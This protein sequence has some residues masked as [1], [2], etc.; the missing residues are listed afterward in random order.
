ME[1]I[2]Y[3]EAEKVFDLR[4]EHSTY[5]MQVRE[6]DTLVHL[7]YGSPVGDA[8]ITDRIVC[9]D[10]G[11]SGNPYE[12]EKDRTFSLDTLPQ[13][14]TAYGN[15]DYR[16]NGLETEQADGSDTANLKFESYEIT[17]GKYSLKGL[18]AMFAK[19]DEAETLEIVLT[20]RVSGLK[21]HLLYGVFPHLDVITRAVRL[22][23]TGTA[24]V[25]VKKAMSMEMDY[26]Y[27][28]LDAVHFYGRH[29][30]ERQMERTHLGHGNW[31]VGSIR[32]TSSHHHN[33]FV[34]LCDRNTE[35]TYGDCYGYALAYSGNFLFETEV[36]QVGHTRVAMG[37]H[38]YH[39]SWTLEQGESFETPEV[40]MAYSA[41]GF[42]KLSRIYHDAYRSNLIRS[43]YTEQPRPILVN[44]WEATYFD[45]D[46]DKIYHIA[47]EAKNIGLDM[48]VLDDGWFG[49]RDND[50]CALGDWE[51]NEEKIKGGLPAL[52]ERIH[53]LGLKFG[54]WVEPEMISE[55]SDLYRAHP[56]WILQT[57]QRH[58]CH[59]RNQY[60]LDFSRKEVV[61]CIYEMMYKIL[62]EAKV[63][64]IKWDMNRSITEC[65]SAAL[66]ADRQGEVFHRYILGVYDLYERLNTA[67]PQILFESCASGG[68]RFDPGI[69]YYAPQGWTSDDTDAAERV[70][71]QYG[72]SMCYP[73]SS[74]GSHV[75]VVP[76][77]Q[78]NRKTPLHTRANV[79]YFGTF[80]YELDLNKL[81]DEEI[82]EV[83]QQITF[84]KEYRELIQFGTFYRLKSP[85]EGNET[86]WMT[87]SE[88]KKTA[89]VFWYRERN[90]VNADF[91]RVRLQGLDPDLIYR[92]EY[93]ETENYGDELMNLGLL[94][95]DCTAGE[96]TSED[97]PC[98]DYES[99]IYVLTAK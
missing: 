29:I 93:N 19:E 5:Q 26:E 87:V 36:D 45:F 6:Y 17:K 46:A 28:E 4:T 24:P 37:I 92:N 82:S 78:L 21:A 76:N 23:N 41:E 27:R 1:W 31:S 40:I 12:A 99:R 84:M 91:T 14:Y 16:I 38:P 42:G 9:V 74:M 64:Y 33:P 73:V 62:S 67:F 83:K 18:P 97:E 80:G 96:P 50:W 53:G 72:T 2:K 32:G 95:T 13:E 48:F 85:F 56:D 81:S 20:D 58:S 51:V 66:P 10:R 68:G 57:P 15:G 39:F 60:V 71:I 54:L 44:N 70:K 8:L 75:S 94:T 90:V 65:C 77:H 30:M 43:K 79:A 86:A 88:D 59:G 35:E 25:T 11:F 7:Y 3:H 22:E 34:I 69:L 49:K 47:E 52:A 89:L 55:D 63:S 61:D 98:T